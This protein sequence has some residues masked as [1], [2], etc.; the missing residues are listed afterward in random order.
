MRHRATCEIFVQVSVIGLWKNVAH[1]S[2][3][4]S[5]ALNPKQL[6][7]SWC[8]IIQ[9]PHCPSLHSHLL[10]DTIFPRPPSETQTW[11]RP[12]TTILWAAWIIKGSGQKWWDHKIHGIFFT[13][14][15]LL[16]KQKWNELTNRGATE[17]LARVPPTLGVA[18]AKTE[19]MNYES[20]FQSAGSLNTMLAS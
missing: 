14:V 11:V 3:R 9:P 15:L 4:V 20:F 10:P 2:K 13:G 6:K 12:S 19:L 7:V 18:N 8:D 17:N 5:T 1:R 16:T